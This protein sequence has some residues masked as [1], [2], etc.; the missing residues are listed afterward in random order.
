MHFH[1]HRALWL[2]RTPNNSTTEQ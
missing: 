2:S 1:I